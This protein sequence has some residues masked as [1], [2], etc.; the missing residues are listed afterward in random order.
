MKT[1]TWNEFRKDN[2]TPD[3][4][5]ET[6]IH[7]QYEDTMMNADNHST[8]GNHNFPDPGASKDGHNIHLNGISTE[9]QNKEI[10]HT[11]KRIHTENG[12]QGMESREMTS[13]TTWG[14]EFH[15]GHQNNT[16]EDTTTDK[17]T[18]MATKTNI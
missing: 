14:E 1:K 10:W 17:Q 12:M 9:Y 16:T 6:D 13:T 2:T 3:N 7:N 18:E 8:K 5:T 15:Q 11:M 4:N